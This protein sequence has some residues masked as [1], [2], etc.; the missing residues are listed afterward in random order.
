[1]KK[2]I[3]YSWQSDL[4]NNNNRSFI[5]DAIARAIKDM[6]ND[7][8]IELS[9]DKDTNGI[10]G[11]PEIVNTIFQKIKQSTIFIADISII[12]K[13]FDGR[14][15]SNPN[16]LFE[17]G[18]AFSALGYEKIICV[19]NTDYGRIE[20]LPFDLRQK[21]IFQ[22]S[23]SKNNKKEENKKLSQAIQWSIQELFKKGL[24]QDELQD[25]F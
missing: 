8:T 5:E 25:Y 2:T 7:F 11:A 24:I 6:K 9:I 14:K 18:F 12:N 15:T 23:T 13:D 10:A 22:Y 19:F 3:F 16:V 4:P 17:L 21:R 1:L 20:D